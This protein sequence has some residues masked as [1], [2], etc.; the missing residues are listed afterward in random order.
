MSDEP[1]DQESLNEAVAARM[2]AMDE[3]LDTPA[4]DWDK[5][6]SAL[7]GATR[8]G[9]Q[10]SDVENAAVGDA[11]GKATERVLMVDP[12]TGQI[13]DRGMMST[14]NLQRARIGRKEGEPFLMSLPQVST[15]EEM[16]AL[17]PEQ[18][19][20]VEAWVSLEKADAKEA[21][22]MEAE[23]LSLPA[24]MGMDLLAAC[25]LYTSPSPR[26]RTRSRMP[27]SA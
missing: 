9:P 23:P 21:A 16:D 26:D 25:L 24:G 18:R 19:K 13:I 1:I 7:S 11:Q 6:T 5:L 17:T 4:R 20:M 12:N 15:Q 2:A 10:R 22:R 8:Q 3:G 14:S 27:S